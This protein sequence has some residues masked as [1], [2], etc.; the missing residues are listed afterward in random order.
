M[1]PFTKTTITAPYFIL[2]VYLTI[3][4]GKLHDDVVVILKLKTQKIQKH[5]HLENTQDSKILKHRGRTKT[6]SHGD[7]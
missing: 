7:Y 2:L 1:N 4:E 3:Y 5:Q 6:S